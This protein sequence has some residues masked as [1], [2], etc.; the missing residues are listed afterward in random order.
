M[1]LACFNDLYQQDT[2]CRA[3]RKDWQ[4][5][6]YTE[7]VFYAEVYVCGYSD[8]INH[9]MNM[10]SSLVVGF[11]RCG[12]LF[13]LLVLENFKAHFLFWD[14]FND[15]AKS[16]SLF[17]FLSLICAGLHDCCENVPRISK[18]YSHGKFVPLDDDFTIINLKKF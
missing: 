9:I 18:K 15:Y 14:N 3:L 8:L 13:T 17:V 11:P 2:S 4:I 5:R 6:T 7:T 12:V 1:I 16:L 10:T